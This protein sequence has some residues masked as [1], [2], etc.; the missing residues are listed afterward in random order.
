M[1]I[2][3]TQQPNQFN[4]AVQPNVWTLSGITTEDGYTLEIF[5]QG[6][7]T[8]I[9]KVR[10]PANPAG[11]AHFDVAKILQAQLGTAFYET[12]TQVAPTPGETYTYYV[13]YGT[14]TDNI[15]TFEPTGSGTNFIF[16]GYDNWRNLN[17]NDTPFNP[18]PTVFECENA[19][20]NNVEYREPYRYLTN[21]PND[22]YPLR[23]SSYHT[24]GFMNKTKGS[25][26]T[27]TDYA[28][29][30]QPAFVRVQFYNSIGG[31]IQ[32]AIYSITEANGLG[33][34][35]DYN[36]TFIPAYETS[37]YVGVVGAGPQNLKDA[38]YWPQSHTAIWNEVTQVW[39]NYS[40]IWNLAT[41]TALVD[42]YVV[43]I[44]SINQCEVAQFGVPP[45]DDA[46]DLLP[47]LGDVIYSQTFQVADPCSK[48]DDVTVSFVNQY[49]VKDYFTFDRR[50]TYGVNTSRQEYYQT[51][52]SWSDATFSIDQHN[53]GSTVFSSEIETQMTLSSNWMDDN[54]SAWLEELYKSP[55]V[56]VYYNG[57]WE[58][59]VITSNNYQQKTYSRDKLFQHVLQVKFANNQRVQRG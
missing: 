51:T 40:V 31:L 7:A 27:G 2:T 53:G 33:P 14:Y 58:P 16:N 45:S 52:G 48:F 4:L 19:A 44:M 56:Q 17:W 55:S 42:H 12:T 49:G 35:P 30:V 34:R 59:A 25:T 39:G 22:S 43:D 18:D 28:L 47:Y 3:V 32:T 57:Q 21:F 13:R 54:T 8:S 11:V 38:G 23:S 36:S 26:T 29:N 10:Q 6:S 1:A 20:V 41:S 50:N 37:E 5:P 15:D 9:A 46:A 24:L